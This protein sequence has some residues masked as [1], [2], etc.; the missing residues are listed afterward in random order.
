MKYMS[1]INPSDA[2]DNKSITIMLKIVGTVCN[3]Q[4][5]YCYEHIVSN[6]HKGSDDFDSIKNYLSKYEEYNH[7]FIVFHGGEPLLAKKKLVAELLEYIFLNFNHHCHVQIQTN[8]TLLDDEWIE[9]F[10]KYIPKLS[11]SISLDPKGKLDLRF[12]E[13]MEYRQVVIDNIKKYADRIENI[14]I[15][16]VVHAYNKDDFIPFILELQKIGISSLTINKYQ[17]EDYSSE[18][19]ISEK[20]YVILL[21]KIFAEWITKKWYINFNI[22]P[23]LALF[24]N[25]ANK[26]CTYLPDENKCSYFNV[27]YDKDDYSDFCDHISN[28]A[29]PKIDKKCL[30]CDLYD[31]CG[32]GCLVEKKDDSFC[33]ARKELFNFIEEVKHGNQSIV[34]K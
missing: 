2:I 33:E 18:Y 13:K 8:G 9:I 29:L 27:F 12:S 34:G 20:E 14:G 3:M 1:N 26:I 17:T 6:E 4:C 23:L 32:G 21:K 10:E 16:S 5:K 19:Y 30:V 25:H 15:I 24:S 31:K 7:V 11:L 22:Q 28:G